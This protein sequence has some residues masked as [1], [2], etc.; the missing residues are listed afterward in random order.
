MNYELPTQQVMGSISASDLSPALKN[1]ILS[2]LGG[3]T[4]VTL[5]NFSAPT[6]TTV[7]IGSATDFATVQAGGQYT[8]TSNTEVIIINGD[9]PTELNVNIEN[10]SARIVI[11]GGDGADTIILT[12]ATARAS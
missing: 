2:A 7:E 4:N 11:A 5:D 10:P 3:G 8:A 12:D 1:A 9:A 6:G